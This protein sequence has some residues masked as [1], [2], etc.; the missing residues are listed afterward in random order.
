MTASAGEIRLNAKNVDKAAGGL[1]G[2][3]RAGEDE[4]RV[5]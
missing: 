4:H 5:S 3:G 1:T 2:R